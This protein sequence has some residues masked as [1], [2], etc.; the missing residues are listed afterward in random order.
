MGAANTLQR[1]TARFRQNA[2]RR[3][4][5]DLIE[6]AIALVSKSHD[7]SPFPSFEGSDSAT[8]DS[9][10]NY[11]KANAFRGLGRGA[12]RVYGQVLLICRGFVW[13]PP[14]G[15]HVAS[16]PGPS[17]IPGSMAPPPSGPSGITTGTAR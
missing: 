11:H 6:A 14:S 10:R 16:N 17:G 5:I 3:N 2:N 15:T 1:V 7:V 9:S 13:G 12:P 4:V 8:N